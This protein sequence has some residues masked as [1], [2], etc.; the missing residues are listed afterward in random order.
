MIYPVPRGQSHGSAGASSSLL[1]GSA[2]AQDQLTCP[3][4]SPPPAPGASQLVSL[5]LNCKVTQQPL[6]CPQGKGNLSFPYPISIDF[7]NL[8]I[9]LK[10]VQNQK[11]STQVPQAQPYFVLLQN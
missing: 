4:R 8:Q 10:L 3:Q 9:F 7:E 1:P 11:G 2:A 6:L 5:F